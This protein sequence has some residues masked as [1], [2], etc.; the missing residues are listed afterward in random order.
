M[1]KSLRRQPHHITAI[2]DFAVHR[3]MYRINE[4]L[5]IQPEKSGFRDYP[6][7]RSDRAKPTSQPQGALTLVKFE[8]PQVSRHHS[9]QL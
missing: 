2:F 7:L 4:Q 6:S 9:I 5:P 1:K 8:A 3:R